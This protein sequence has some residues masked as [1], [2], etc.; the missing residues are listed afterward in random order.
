MN[1]CSNSTSDDRI[2]DDGTRKKFT[3]DVNLY[4][5]LM[6]GSSFVTCIW[7][8]IET[9][10]LVFYQLTKRDLHAFCDS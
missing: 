5:F 3:I 8:A 6:N 10:E 9:L 7:E 1:T 2:V 4:S